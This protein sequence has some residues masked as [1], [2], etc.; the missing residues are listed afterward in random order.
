MIKAIL[1]DIDGVLVDSFESNY[2]YY[3]DFF[4]KVG[5]RPPTKK[6]Y[7]ATLFMT[8]WD[9]IKHH[10]K[11]RDPK[12]IRKLW[13]IAQ[14]TDYPVHLYKLPQK[15]IKIL[16]QLHKKYRLA[17]VT[18]RT[19]RGAFFYID[20]TKTR[21]LFK[22]LVTFE[23]FKKPK[24]HPEPLLVALKRLKIKPRE[25]IY[26]GDTKVDITAAK[27]AGIKVIG[28]KQFSKMPLKGADIVINNFS[29]LPAAIKKCDD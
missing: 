4:R 23:D 3:C 27:A 17:L 9:N 21:Q 16:K 2:K 25:A 18:N 1:F 20:Y 19:R 6:Q 8:I 26:V 24:P 14:K 5:I 29:L 12:K 22:V 11:I 7:R 15:S 28:F 10:A 13:K